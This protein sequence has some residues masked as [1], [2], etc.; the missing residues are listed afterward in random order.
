MVLYTP[1]KPS[2]QKLY[3]LVFCG[4][5]AV[6]GSALAFEHIGG[7]LPCK[8][9]LAQRQ[10]WYLGIPIAGLALLAVLLKLPPLIARGLLLLVGIILFYSL[11]LGINHAGVEWSWWEGPSDCGVVEGGIAKNTGN[12]LEQLEQTVPPSCDEASLR[13][14]GLSF[15][16][17]NA[18]VS[19]VLSFIAFSTALKR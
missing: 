8:L 1:V 18:V 9:C 12:F 4:M 11:Y 3:L 17:W 13:M 7:Y 2:Q 16:G 15:A 5:V 10:P 6:I 19:T 14:F